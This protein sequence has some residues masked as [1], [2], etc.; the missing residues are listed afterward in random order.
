V[1][2]QDLANTMQQSGTVL[3]A[4][5]KQLDLAQ[6]KL[7]CFPPAKFA[8]MVNDLARS[9][10]L[11]LLPNTYIIIT[12]EPDTEWVRDYVAQ[13]LNTA[14]G[15][16]GAKSP[17][18]LMQLP[19]NKTDLDAPTLGAEPRPGITIEA[20]GGMKD[21]LVHFFDSYDFVIRS[22]SHTPDSPLAYLQNHN[23]PIWHADNIAWIA[24]GPGNPW[25]RCATN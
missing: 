3:S 18:W 8:A 16:R 22:T 15:E 25:A 10:Q 11:N 5:K 7:R 19:D 1:A 20:S 14:F 24:I 13:A 17:L 4:T 12:A 9:P 23:L 21:F 2:H 6:L